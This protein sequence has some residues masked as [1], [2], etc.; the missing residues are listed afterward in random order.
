M[1]KLGL[2]GFTAL[3]ALG[4]SSKQVISGQLALSSFPNPP[5]VVHLLKHGRVVSQAPVAADGTFAL[6]MHKGKGLQV[7]FLGYR[8]YTGLVFP[9]SAT[10]NTT[11]A[12]HSGASSFDLGQ[13][14]FIGDTAAVQFVVFSAS[15]DGDNVECEDGI[16]AATGAVC[17]DNDNEGDTCE[18]DDGEE[19]DDEESGETCGGDAVDCVDGID[20]ATGAEC[21]GGPSA[22]QDDGEEDDDAETDDA[23]LSNAAVAE[24]NLPASIGGCGDEDDDE[25]NDDEEDDD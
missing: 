16:D 11:F 17:V 2:V 24:H 21:D 23:V 4:C 22:N 13:V 20:S 12:I 10:I 7:Q 15:T 19:N 5:T 25:G 1:N 6:P 3:L 14:R 9:R 18:E 8:D